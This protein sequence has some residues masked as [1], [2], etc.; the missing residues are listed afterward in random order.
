MAYLKQLSTDSLTFM[1]LSG[2][3]KLQRNL[4]LCIVCN[5]AVQS[6]AHNKNDNPKSPNATAFML[7]LFTINLSLT[8][9]GRFN[10]LASAQTFT[11]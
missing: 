4:V 7:V 2:L 5:Q 11:V 6:S 3:T 9:V 8:K 1:V 10:G